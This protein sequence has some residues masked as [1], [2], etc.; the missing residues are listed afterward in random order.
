MRNRGCGVDVKCVAMAAL[1]AIGCGTPPAAQPGHLAAALGR[2]TAPPGGLPVSNVPQL[3]AVTFDDNFNPEGMDWATGFFRPLVNPT[4]AHNAA[5]FDGMPVRTTFPS[6]S[7]YVSGMRTSWQTAVD[8]GHEISNHT[9]DHSDGIAFS[10]DQWRNQIVNCTS[11]LAANLHSGGHA[12]ATVGFRSPYLHYDDNLFTVLTENGFLYDSSIMGGWADSD[13]PKTAPWPYTMDSGSPDAD[14]IY[15]RWSGRNVVPVTAHPGLWELPVATVFV[16]DDT[17]AAQ[18]GFPAGLR[19][20]VQNRLAGAQNP[21]FFEPSTGKLVGMDITM[22]LDAQMTRAEALAT[23]EYT[24]DQRLAGNRAPMVFV[25]HTH[26][27]ASN[28][29]GNAPGAPNTNDRRRIIQ[30]FVSYA[31]TKPE[32]RMRPLSD[33]TQWM[34]SPAPLGVSVCTPTSCAAVGKSCGSIADGCGG[35]LGCGSCGTDRR[36]PA[37]TSARRRPAAAARR[38]S[39]A[40]R[41]ACATPPSCTR[42]SCTSAWR[43]RPASTAAARAAARRACTAARSRPITRRGARPPGR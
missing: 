24:L 26:V 16:P 31:L 5:T 36:A 12:L 27:Y 6:N 22:L 21:N 43:R 17:L 15:T 39:A 32:V 4:G 23:L 2:S 33:L 34:K 8:D 38:P 3:V 20:R 29:D 37:A 10:V 30:D 42:A 25:A 13:G 18:Y 28:W 11:Q 35:T 19:Q 41:Q 1:A 40:T 7:T 9:V 14:A